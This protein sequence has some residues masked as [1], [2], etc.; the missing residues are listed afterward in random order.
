MALLI[1]GTIAYLVGMSCRQGANESGTRGST[2]T[3]EQRRGDLLVFPAELRAD[4]PMVNEFVEQA[5]AVCAGGDY[6]RFRLLW[7]AKDDPLRR[8]EYGQG[9]QAVQKIEIRALEK[10]I[11]ATG[12]GRDPTGGDNAYVVFAELNL[13][14][15]HRAAKHQPRRDAVMLLVQE[16]G[17]WRL[18]NAPKGLR[19]WIKE[20]A[21]VPQGPAIQTEDLPQN[22]TTND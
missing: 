2:A 8:E 22:P 12:S 20:R 5:M 18:A 13:D 3:Q 10:V 14:P 15:N 17:E 16:Q 6:A 19:A 11:L 9:W 4:D 21:A 7:S 1:C